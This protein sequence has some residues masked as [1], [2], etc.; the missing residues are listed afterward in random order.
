MTPEKNVG[1]GCPPLSRERHGSMSSTKRSLIALVLAVSSLAVPVAAAQVN[2][3]SYATATAAAVDSLDEGPRIYW[4]DDSDAVV[5]YLCGGEVKARRLRARG[6]LRFNGLCSDSAVEYVIS[7]RPPKV[8]PFVFKDVPQILA[9][10]DIHGEY[11]ALVDFLQRAGA[12]D[13]ELHWSW[14]DGHLVVD[15]DV[16]DR[17]D[18]VT[19]TLWLIYRL[20]QEARAAGGRVHYVLGNHE[21]MVMRGDN[22]YVNKRYL[23][24]IARTTDIDHED[25]FGP[26][27]EL[28]RWLRTKNVAVKLNDIV[29]VHGGLSPDAAERGFDLK[30][31]NEFGRRSIDAR[32][33]EIVFSDTLWFVTGTVGPLWYRGY[34]GNRREYLQTT[35]EQ[36][37]QILDFYDAKAI[38]VGHTEI[39]SLE[40]LYDGRVFGIDVPVDKIGF[41]GLLWRDDEFFRVTSQGELVPLRGN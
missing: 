29:F 19:E 14:G 22:R 25:L 3:S 31:L 2:D 32:S 26:D 11:E 28:G 33:Y 35:S 20:E 38:V 34:H 27:M 37:D 7:A 12:I 9:V 23:D 13:D 39:D 16:F 15:G 8:Q 41:Q 6:E 21:M 24:G 10:S 17:G 1:P 40:S 30:L 5:F 4:Q 36:L 18:R